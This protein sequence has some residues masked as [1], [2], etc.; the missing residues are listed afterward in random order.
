MKCIL[1]FALIAMLSSC[2]SG[3]N[4]DGFQEQNLN[5]SELNELKI[6]SE[7]ITVIKVHSDSWKK[8]P[9]GIF[10]L[11]DTMFA[12]RLETNSR[13]IIGNIDEINIYNDRIYVLDK[14]M[15]R[16]IY[17]FDLN[18][19][20][21]GPIGQ[22]GRGPGEYQILGGMAIDKVNDELIVVCVAK[23][24]I[25]RYDLV[26]NFLGDI[27]V[28]VAFVDF[29]I[30]ENGNFVLLAGDEPNAHLGEE[31]SRRII[32]ITD[33]GGNIISY[34]PK[35]CTY[36]EDVKMSRLGNLMVQ[37]NVI[38]YSYKF[39]DT[40]FQ[41]NNTE[42]T[43]KYKIDLGPYSLD[44]ERLKNLS[45]LDF[46]DVSNRLNNPIRFMGNHFQ[47]EDFFL[48]QIAVNEIVFSLYYH[49]KSNRL[50]SSLTN[51]TNEDFLWG[52]WVASYRDY[53]IASADAHSI[54]SQIEN[55]RK[56][57]PSQ[58]P[59]IYAKLSLDENFEISDTDNPILLFFRLKNE[60]FEQ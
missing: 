55:I 42:I 29:K 32:Y 9:K 51:P 21:I 26:G 5:I 52:S 15:A 13:N 27:D 6:N 18:G 4:Q 56:N 40:I 10:N 45:T 16:M 59:K 38:S 12:V 19:N 57:N 47:T 53:F 7:G 24:K 48:F 1:C 41:V 20:F 44:R 50:F 3:V 17:A 60:C 34:G 54:L 2:H 49:K 11:I 8:P 33:N 23:R 43:A 35:Y 46:I 28:Q 36:F 58:L 37:N 25:L 30:L 39:S 31:M 14:R 22:R